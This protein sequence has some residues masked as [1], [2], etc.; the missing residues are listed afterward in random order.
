MDV[1]ERKGLAHDPEILDMMGQLS[2]MTKE[3][4]IPNGGAHKVVNRD[5]RIAEIQ[6][7]PAFTNVMH[8]DHYKL[9]S[10]WKEMFAPKRQEG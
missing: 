9:M 1:I 7:D 8:P 5:A 6:K 10:E 4:A 3:D 2:D